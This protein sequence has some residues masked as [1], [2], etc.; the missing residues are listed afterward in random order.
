MGSTPT[1]TTCK[2]L[3][4]E[5]EMG[6]FI[7]GPPNALGA[8]VSIVEAEDRLFGFVL[9][10]DWSARDIQAFEYVPLGR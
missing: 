5:L 10:N 8:P 2:K 3:D 9:L 4:I 6:F 1:Y 7:G